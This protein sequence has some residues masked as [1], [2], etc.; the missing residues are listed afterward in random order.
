MSSSSLSPSLSLR[1][2]AVAA[3][4]PRLTPLSVA[5]LVTVGVGYLATFLLPLHNG[6]FYSR[7]FSV[8]GGWLWR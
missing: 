4:L 1:L 6:D 3:Q 7:T 5:A 2:S 8:G